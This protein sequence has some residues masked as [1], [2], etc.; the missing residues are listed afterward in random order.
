MAVVRKAET[1][2]DLTTF[3][4]TD[5]PRFA[6]FCSFAEFPDVKCAFGKQRR[7]GQNTAFRGS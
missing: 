5:M 3:E 7:N 6:L 4:G 1:Y 2:Y